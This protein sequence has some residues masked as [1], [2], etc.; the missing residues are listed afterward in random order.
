MFEIIYHSPPVLAVA[1]TVALTAAIALATTFLWLAFKE[2]NN[3]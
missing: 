3:E 2:A 1:Y